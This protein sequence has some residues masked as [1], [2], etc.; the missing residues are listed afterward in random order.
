MDW[1]RV[2]YEQRT[3]NSDDVYTYAL[4]IAKC[5]ENFEKFKI[6]GAREMF[7]KL[8]PISLS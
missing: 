7:D 3:Y 4:F 5:F 1:K 2:A 6:G 8:F